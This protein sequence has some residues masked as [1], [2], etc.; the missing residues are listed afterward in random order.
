MKRGDRVTVTIE[1]LTAKGDGLAACDGRG[2]LV[3]RTVP[4]DCVEVVL[5]S[6]RKGRFQATVEGFVKHGLPRQDSPCSH[7]GTCGGCR[8]QDLAYRDQLQLKGGMVGRALGSRGLSIADIGSTLASP[9]P[10]FYRNKM[11]FS[12]AGDGDGG[13]VLGL[14]VRH[15]YNRVFDLDACHLQSECSN[16]IVHSVRRHANSLSLSAY[17][18]R[19]HEGL[20]RFLVIREGKQTGERLVNLV[21]S[22]YP[23]R[24]VDDLM[25][26]VAADVPGITTA[27]ITLHTGKAQV[28]VGQAAYPLWGDGRITER[29]GGLDF[30][31]SPGSFFQTNTLQAER[32]YSLVADLAG[33]LS[34]QVVLDLYCGTGAIGLSLA[35]SAHRV[36]GLEQAPAAAD[37]ARGNA[38]RNG[39]ENCEFL[40]DRTE[41]ALPELLARDLH[42]DVAVVDP[43]RAGVHARALRALSDLGPPVLIYVSCNA[44][45]LADDISVLAEAYAVDAVRPVDLFPQTPHCEVVARLRRRV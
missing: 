10:L 6:R 38:L 45:S 41:D 3:Q 34:G 42:I 8:W 44:E 37:D 18:L 9:D 25:E 12:F 2:V 21:V 32:L 35:G 30:V 17:D 1:E 20:L 14:H 22:E 43:P 23:L 13:V 40:A 33:D 27:I 31:V 16:R 28:A 36:V 26:Q 15:R 4:G 24:A 19:T 5:G 29:C 11:E 39:I 7:F